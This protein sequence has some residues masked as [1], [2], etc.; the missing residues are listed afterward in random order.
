MRFAV[1]LDGVLFERADYPYLGP[2]NRELMLTLK[3]LQAHGHKVYM[4]TAREGEGLKIAMEELAKL[5]FFEFDEYEFPCTGKIRADF[6]I[7]DRAIQPTAFPR[8]VE[9]FLFGA[10][11]EDR[12]G[13][14]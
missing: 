14:E 11:I 13:K 1:D 9:S 2:V 12:R 8:I 6:Y 4:F 5:K 10:S 7:D 3:E